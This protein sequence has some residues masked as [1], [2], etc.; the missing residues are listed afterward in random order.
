[1]ARW[2]K[3]GD[4]GMRGAFAT[5]LRRGSCWR[6]RGRTRASTRPK[7]GSRSFEGSEQR[8]RLSVG[9]RSRLLLRD[10]RVNDSGLNNIDLSKTV[11]DRFDVAHPQ[12]GNARRKFE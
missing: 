1:G 5:R 4:G 8:P 9:H 2:E 10:R 11:V 7:V 12:Q 3:R 6:A